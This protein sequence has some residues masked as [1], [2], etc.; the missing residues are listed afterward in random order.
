[1]DINTVSIG[2]KHDFVTAKRSPVYKTIVRRQRQNET[3]IA[4]KVKPKRRAVAGRW[5]TRGS[6]RFAIRMKILSRSAKSLDWM[7]SDVMTVPLLRI[8]KFHHHHFYRLISL[9]RIR[10]TLFALR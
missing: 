7:L 2:V 8:L 9:I 6:S 1:V 3:A 10:M 4:G 5:R